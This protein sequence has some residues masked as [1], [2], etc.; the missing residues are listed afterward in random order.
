MGVLQ[1]SILGPLLFLI[2]I[3]D[4]AKCLDGFQGY[5]FADDTT[6]VKKSSDLI[7]LFRDTNLALKKVETWF[8]LNKLSIN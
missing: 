1:G 3:N 5:L 7:Q 8:T 2:Y 6:L 4:F